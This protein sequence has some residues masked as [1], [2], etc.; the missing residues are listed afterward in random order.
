M[1]LLNAR[2]FL[3]TALIL[4]LFVLAA[5]ADLHLPNNHKGYAPKQPIAFSHRLHAGELGVNCLY[6]HYAARKSK[7]A[8]IPPLSICMNCHKTVSTGFDQQSAENIAA[9]K[10]EREPKKLISPEIA[11]IY[12][13][14]GL[15]EQGIA[16]PALEPSPVAWL[17][18]HNL[19]DFVAFDHRVHVAKEIACQSCHGPVQSMDRLQQFSDL[20]MGWCVECHRKSEASLNLFGKEKSIGG[21]PAHSTASIDCA[22]CH[23]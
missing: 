18:V 14:L 17:R 3:L 10:E 11:K 13:A 6:C 8:G 22:V 9:K 7:T 4:G 1:T 15:D 16:D 5:T 23:Y 21:K 12:R 19:P 2:I 20:S